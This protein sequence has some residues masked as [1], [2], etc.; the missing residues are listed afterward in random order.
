M[1]SPQGLKNDPRA[2]ATCSFARSLTILLKYVRL[3]GAEHSRVAAQFETTWEEL[4][5]ALRNGPDS[6]FLLGVSG[7][8]LLLD[9]VPLENSTALASFS[10]L[11]STAGIASI[12][13]LRSLTR[14]EFNLF[15]HAFAVGGNKPRLV[16][17]QLK[18]TLPEKGN[19]RMNEVRFVAQDSATGET[20]LL[21]PVLASGALGG[22]DLNQLKSWLN[23]PQK[24]I[25][26]IAAAEGAR[27]ANGEAQAGTPG[28]GGGM[29]VPAG[30]VVVPAGSI[31][32]PAGSAA[33]KSDATSADG[34]AVPGGSV[35]V[36]AGSIVVPAGSGT[37]APGSG[38]GTGTGWGFGTGNVIPINAGGSPGQTT[39]I[40]GGLL[41]FP[42]VPGQA[43]RADEA[44]IVNLIRMM[45]QF[46]RTSV[47][48]G[49]DAPPEIGPEIAQL[50][51]AAQ[52][53]LQQALASLAAAV[54][55]PEEPDTP[56]LV[57]LCER[58]A[59]RF[60]L[61]RFERGEVR[62]NAVHQMMERM[63]KES[64][65][66]RKI[67]N[68]QEEKMARAG[69]M[70]ETHADILDRQFWAQV[71]DSGKR[72]VLLSE[73]AWCIPARNVAQFVD[74]L[75][76]RGDPPSAVA[77]LRNYVNCVSNSDPQ[78]R[79]K[80]ATGVTEL[81]ELYARCPGKMF[82]YA[83]R[84]VAAQLK[85]ESD[86]ELKK[87]LSSSF[88]RLSQEAATQRNYATVQQ[89]LDS[90][91]ELAHHDPELGQEMRPRLGIEGRLPHFIEGALKAPTV[92]MGLGEVMRRSPRNAVSQLAARFERCV[93]REEC[94]RLL[95]LAREVGNDGVEYLREVLR[96][97]PAAEAAF[98]VGLLS[99]LDPQALVDLLPDRLPS[100]NRSYHDM[101]VRQLSSA[102]APERSQIFTYLLDR[103]DPLVLP[104]TFDE[105]GLT[106]DPAVAQV[107]GDVIEGRILPAAS[108][109]L[110]VKA[111]EAMG[112]LRDTST[113]PLLRHLIEQRQVFRWA[114]DREIRLAALQTFIK[115]DPGQGIALIS[116]AGF[117]PAEL[118]LAPL[119]AAATSWTRQRRYPR[120]VPSKPLPVLVT[121]SG[122]RSSLMVEALSLGGGLATTDTALPQYC[123]GML[124]FN[125]GFRNIKAQAL[126][127]QTSRKQV[128]FE[129]AN[130]DLP[131]RTKLRA[132]LEKEAVERKVAGDA[133]VSTLPVIAAEQARARVGQVTP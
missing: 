91:D 48:K 102:G 108:P 73:D 67:L 20:G 18:K 124:Y 8:K 88:I 112:R 79:Q 109:Y 56:V 22:G 49:S 115:I 96:V 13:F 105:L 121:A 4:N 120:V 19:I 95:D 131:E 70:A 34:T 39:G 104:E 41:H 63:A 126:M 103:L 10:Q 31:V 77:V 81:C 69:L 12:H 58:M 21:A 9:G 72:A 30:S 74:T 15:V 60:A 100:W 99:R 101:V 57:K 89:V 43:G 17:E 3:Y 6:G 76:E 5:S 61:E 133:K 132:L 36:P 93:E 42:A 90:M 86:A 87:L 7:Q 11:L 24:L 78:A 71:P 98:S 2:I 52:V 51:P 110:K 125:L 122:R 116:P 1:D 28:E 113:L 32:L 14:S 123:E 26:L 50:K 29:V 38:A 94:E 111:I 83:V 53:T 66:L 68:A 106:G 54:P 45:T 129:I 37:D 64:E 25:Q 127:R 62:I 114:H 128:T 46:A 33:G 107:L 35:V 119:D 118:Q 27:S 65:S 80:I 47:E 44:D 75:L 97:K 16:A 40:P 130:M 92:P 117:E 23:D 82:E 59:I 85:H 84:A 55:M